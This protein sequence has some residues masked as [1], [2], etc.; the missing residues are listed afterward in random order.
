MTKEN[1][2]AKKSKIIQINEEG[3]REHL[4]EIVREPV[5]ETLNAL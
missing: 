2:T 1:C 4:G 5:Q 3:V